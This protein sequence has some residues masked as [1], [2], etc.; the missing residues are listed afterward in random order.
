VKQCTFAGV[1]TI[2]LLAVPA[3]LNAQDCSGWQNWRVRGTYVMHGSGYVDM[4][5]TLPGLGLPSGMVPMT[6]VGAHTYDGA[7]GGTG[8]VIFNAAGSQLTAKLVDM[9]YSVKSDCSVQ[10]SFSMQI[11]GLGTFGPFARVY[12]IVPKQDGLEMHMMF[13]GTAPGQPP[14]AAIDSGVA[15]RISVQP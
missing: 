6:W 14:G 8:W 10:A 7:G 11:P 4:A 2:G 1:L 9:S 15:Y 12:V 13:A 5:K 3:A